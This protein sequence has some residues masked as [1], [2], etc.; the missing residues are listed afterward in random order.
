MTP[1]ENVRANP[2][3]QAVDPAAVKREELRRERGLRLVT[4][5]EEGSSAGRLPCG[6]YGFTYAPLSGSP[7]FAKHSYHSFEVQKLETGECRL[8]VFVTPH[9][10]ARI[11]T[12][13]E[14]IAVH[15][16][17]AA[18]QE[19]IEIVALS[20]GRLATRKL[21]PS[22]ENGNWLEATVYPE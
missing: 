12:A 13:S 7:L 8:V 6:V 5:E 15:V 17:P 19:A 18:W 16:Y 11:R 9:E 2:L 21:N 10:S 4:A 1:T 14:G 22:R 3:S 20:L